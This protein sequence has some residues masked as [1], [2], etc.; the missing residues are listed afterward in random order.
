MS[1]SVEIDNNVE[2]SCGR[3]VIV[4]S[5]RDVIVDV[6]PGAVVVIITDVVWPGSSVVKMY[7]EPGNVV[8]Y[9][10]VSVLTDGIEIDIDMKV[11]VIVRSMREVRTDA[12]ACTVVVYMMEVVCPGSR[13]VIVRVEGKG[14]AVEIRV[15]VMI[16]NMVEAG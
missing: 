10:R 3:G 12:G 16:E 8:V 14:D 1:V 11:W 5:T 15:S 2:A 6:E 13:V 9:R 7:V 4:R